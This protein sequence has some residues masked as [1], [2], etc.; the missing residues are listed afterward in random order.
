M[1][2][3]CTELQNIS[4]RYGVPRFD[5]YSIDMQINSM[6]CSIFLFVAELA[7][8]YLLCIIYHLYH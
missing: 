5:L 6:N 2:Y 1:N 3:R 7:A 8:F 4:Y